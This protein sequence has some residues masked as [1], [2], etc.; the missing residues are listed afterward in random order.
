LRAA[1]ARGVRV[2]VLIDAAGASAVASR[3]DAVDDAGGD[4]RI[5]SPFRIRFMSRYV[6]RTHKKLLITDGALAFTGGAGFSLHWSSGRRRE[7]PWHDRMFMLR[8][9]VVRQVERVF[10]ADFHRWRPRRERPAREAPD[11]TIDLTP[12]GA[13]NLRVLRGWPDAR[14]FRATLLQAIAG[15]RERVWIG[16]PYFIPAPQLIAAL[17]GAMKRGADVRF[18][19]PSGN[20]AH[21]LLWHAMRRHYGFFLKRGAVIHEYTDAFYHAKLAIIDR[22]A[23]IVGSSNLDYWSWNRNAEIDI[24][25][26]DPATVDAFAACF[27]A[28]R[29]KSRVVMRAELTFAS[30]WSRWKQTAAGWIERWL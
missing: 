1:A 30:I 16:T 17:R 7:G 20:Y 6:H 12:A 22:T 14:D 3:L 26:T 5:Y 2:R 11:A 24:V 23:A 4:V 19:F 29:A 8:G 27:E 25:A 18:V 10:E 13:S 28:D 21:P 15:A 9:P